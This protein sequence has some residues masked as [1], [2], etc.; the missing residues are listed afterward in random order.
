MVPHCKVCEGHL[1]PLHPEHRPSAPGNSTPHL[2]GENY[3]SLIVSPVLWDASGVEQSKWAS[4]NIQIPSSG[5][6]DGHMLQLR[7]TRKY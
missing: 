2:P 6:R 1:S 7:P 5:H 3:S 4:I